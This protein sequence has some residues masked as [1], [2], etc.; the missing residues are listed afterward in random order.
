[1]AVKGRKR[2]RYTGYFAL[3]GIG[4]GL[5]VEAVSRDILIMIGTIIVFLAFGLMIDEVINGIV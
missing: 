3:L 2:T 1:M 4:A 5:M